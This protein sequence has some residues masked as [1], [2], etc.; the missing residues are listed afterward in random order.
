MY[1]SVIKDVDSFLDFSTKK[2]GRECLQDLHHRL[3]QEHCGPEQR[4]KRMIISVPGKLC[5]DEEKSTR[6][7]IYLFIVIVSIDFVSKCLA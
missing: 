7:R 1:H 6:M 2:G 4:N 3:Y 5:I